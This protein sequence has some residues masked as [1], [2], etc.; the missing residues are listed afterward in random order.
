MRSPYGPIPDNPPVA[1]IEESRFFT[2]VLFALPFGLA[3][4]S[5]ITWIGSLLLF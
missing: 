5:G 1:L 4:W 3:A 2:G